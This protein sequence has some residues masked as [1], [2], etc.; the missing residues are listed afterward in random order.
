M[1]DTCKSYA[2][3]FATK[4]FVTVFGAVFYYY[5]MC[6]LFFVGAFVYFFFLDRIIF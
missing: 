3:F 1:Y 4:F 5:T 6:N 2:K